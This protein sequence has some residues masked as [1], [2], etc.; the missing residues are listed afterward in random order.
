MLTLADWMFL[1]WPDLTHHSMAWSTD[2]NSWGRD[3]NRRRDLIYL[4]HPRFDSRG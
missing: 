3:L 1:T 2:L 4:L